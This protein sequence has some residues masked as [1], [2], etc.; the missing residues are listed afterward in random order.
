MQWECVGHILTTLPVSISFFFLI[1]SL[2]SGIFVLLKRTQGWTKPVSVLFDHFS[3][4]FLFI[5]ILFFNVTLKKENKRLGRL[6][7]DEW[8][9]G[10][11]SFCLIITFISSR[12]D[13]RS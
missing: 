2:L 5:G 11:P 3:A 4:V 9:T 13:N 8:L 12:E 10:W 6:N 1:L 7:T